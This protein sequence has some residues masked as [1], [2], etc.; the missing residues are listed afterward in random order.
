MMD[1]MAPFFVGPADGG[2]NAVVEPKDD[3]DPDAVDNVP[4]ENS[5]QVAVQGLEDDDEEV[6]VGY[7][8]NEYIKLEDPHPDELE[9][10]GR[11]H[12]TYVEN[13][14]VEFNLS[15]IRTATADLK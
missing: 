9:G 4:H 7:A 14:R 12:S 5:M 10:D 6:G 2:D 11:V 15:T 3:D 8:N 13:I 1:N